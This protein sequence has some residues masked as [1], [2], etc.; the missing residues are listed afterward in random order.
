VI[1]LNFSTKPDDMWRY[2]TA[3]SWRSLRDRADKAIFE[4][5]N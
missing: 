4:I 5:V 3:I 1:F 2:L